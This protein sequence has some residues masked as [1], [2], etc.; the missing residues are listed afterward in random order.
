MA[1]VI[2]PEKSLSDR[3][4]LL[5][6]ANL[7]KFSVGIIM[8]MVLVRLLSQN[9]YG[10]YQQMVLISNTVMSLLTLGLPT[11]VYYFYAHTERERLPALIMQTTLLLGAAGIVATA[12]V[13]F[14]A[15]PIAR[16]LNNPE[17]AGLL[18]IYA[19]SVAFL[20][21][22]EHSIALLIAQDRY[23]LALSV[24]IGETVVRVVLLLVPLWM[25][26]GF[27]GLIIAIVVFGFLRFV[28]RTTIM[29]RNKGLCFKDWRKNTFAKEQLHYSLP[30]TLTS[31]AGTIAGF[32]NRGIV[33]AA[34]SPAQFAIYAVGRMD[35]PFATVFQASIANVLRASLPPLVRDGKLEEVAHIIRDAT[36]RLSIIVLPSFVFLFGFAPEFINLLF[37]NAY[38]DS[39]PI[40]RISVFE[41]PLHM[42][43][44]S[45]IPQIFGQTKINLYVNL[46]VAATLV[47]LTYLLLKGIG[48]YG[49]AIAAVV[50][51]YL[52]SILF[53]RVVLRF[54]N[55][56]LT[57]VLPVA[58]LMRVLLAASAAYAVAQFFRTATSTSFLNFFIV[59]GIYSVIFFVI[60]ALIK[61]FN[62]DDINLMRRWGGKLIP[63]LSLR[64]SP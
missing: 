15:S 24:E 25:G 10:S 14:G 46:W 63:A 51:Q 29:F 49:P 5:I 26:W 52:G 53:L 40:F 36:R 2:P 54:T 21:A 23:K 55:S 9:D 8:P 62:K 57:D 20:I 59:A 39:V 17:M 45:P 48:F 58:G 64:N 27:K 38:D 31:L 33:A 30:L 47:V 37:T 13:Y 56:R 35:F 6:L 28:V 60:A 7:V 41:V 22:S 11:S 18:A 19:F 34:F 50:S 3:A 12:I 42:F 4:A 1:T 16:N 44:L 61:V 43:F 32:F